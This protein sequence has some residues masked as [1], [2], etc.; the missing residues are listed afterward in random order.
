[1]IPDDAAGDARAHLLDPSVM[2][3]PIVWLASP[4][5]QGVHGQRIVAKD[6]A[7]WLAGR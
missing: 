1:M 7:A 5:A 3:D 2:A 6:F 4:D